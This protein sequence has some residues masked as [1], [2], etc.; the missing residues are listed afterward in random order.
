MRAPD[1]VVLL[2][3]QQT[4]LELAGYGH[5]RVLPFFLRWPSCGRHP[6][7]TPLSGTVWFSRL[8]RFSMRWAGGLWA[9]GIAPCVS[10]ARSAGMGS[11]SCVSAMSRLVGCSC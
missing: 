5:A 7:G 3:V 6:I 9:A 4:A 2:V 10:W 8:V 1:D 11:A